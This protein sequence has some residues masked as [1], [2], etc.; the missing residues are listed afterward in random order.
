MNN[1]NQ[2]L[3]NQLQWVV[4]NH[5]NQMSRLEAIIN[6]FYGKTNDNLRKILLSLPNDHQYV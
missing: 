3:A 4:Q 2:H 6:T 5:D 1:Y